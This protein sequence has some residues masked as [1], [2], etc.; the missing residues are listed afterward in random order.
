[1][2]GTQFDSRSET[3]K[4][5]VSSHVLWLP[6]QGSFTATSS[7]QKAPV[8][9]SF[10]LS[11]DLCCQCELEFAPRK[12]VSWSIMKGKYMPKKCCPWCRKLTG[13]LWRARWVPNSCGLMEALHLAGPGGTQHEQHQLAT[14]FERGWL[15]AS[16]HSCFMQPRQK[17]V[18]TSSQQHADMFDI[19]LKENTPEL[20]FITEG[21]MN[22]YILSK[23]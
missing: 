1:M 2:Q 18:I 15:S 5:Q 8:E 13:Q 16:L 23:K 10:V 6:F 17:M 9:M 4:S 14:S 19:I 21:I 20:S 22:W 7:R 3:R 11:K 12:P